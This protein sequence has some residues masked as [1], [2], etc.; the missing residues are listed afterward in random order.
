MTYFAL[1]EA[2]GVK[3]QTRLLEYFRKP[4]TCFLVSAKICDARAIG[5]WRSLVSAW[6]SGAQGRRFK[7]GRPDHFFIAQPAVLPSTYDRLEQPSGA[8]HKLR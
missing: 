6:A 8:P 4:F 5:A 1:T 3:P 2:Y 7:S